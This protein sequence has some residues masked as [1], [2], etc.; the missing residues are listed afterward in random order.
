MPRICATRRTTCS[1]PRTRLSRRPSAPARAAL[2]A[3]YVDLG[4][5]LDETRALQT[6]IVPAATAALDATREGYRSG[7]VGYL[8]VLDAQQRLAEARRAASE[9]RTAYHRARIEVEH[10]IGRPLEAVEPPPIT[11]VPSGDPS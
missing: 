6:E 9:A 1:Q 2:T 10:W 4:A 7:K 8:D 5:T 3:A 11:E